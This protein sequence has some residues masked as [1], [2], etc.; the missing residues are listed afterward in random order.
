MAGN[1]QAMSK[2]QQAFDAPL[3]SFIT[4]GSQSV[5]AYV[6]A[7]LTAALTLYIMVYG[8]AVMTGRVSDPLGEFVWR[9]LKLGA[10]LMLA[11]NAGNYNTFVTNV[12]FELLPRELSNAVGGQFV[13]DGTKWDGIIMQAANIQMKLAKD[14]GW[15]IPANLMSALAGLTVVVCTG[16]LAAI[17]F[18][19]SLYAKMA[20]S[21]CL[22]LGPVF[23]ALAMFDATRRFTENWLGTVLNFVVLQVLVAAIGSLLLSTYAT[24][25][26]GIQSGAYGDMAGVVGQVAAF[27]IVG[28]YLFKELPSIASALVGGGFSLGGGHNMVADAWHKYKP[29]D[30]Q[31]TSTSSPATPAKGAKAA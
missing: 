19:I 31:K 27:C 3:Q 23:V 16:M 20:L 12:F 17:G 26:G 13:V 6:S 30:E 4:Q 14:A 7:P 5:S 28:C 21:L 9:C 2:L 18:V 22:A 29:K 11:A 10:I 8:F 24:L 1:M 25:L 15:D